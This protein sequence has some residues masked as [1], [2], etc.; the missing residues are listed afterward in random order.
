MILYSQVIEDYIL[1]QE[2]SYLLSL[3]TSISDRLNRFKTPK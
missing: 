3:N 1:T 2:I